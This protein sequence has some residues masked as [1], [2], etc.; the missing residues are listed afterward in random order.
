MSTEP[1]SVL[2]EAVHLLERAGHR[3]VL[4]GAVARQTVFDS[5]LGRHPYRATRNVDAAVRV[6]DWKQYEQIASILTNGGRSESTD[7]RSRS[8]REGSAGQVREDRAHLPRVV[9]DGHDV[10]TIFDN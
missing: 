9:D 7:P 10:V 6:S 8:R 4:V 1:L 3:V 5:R 2:A